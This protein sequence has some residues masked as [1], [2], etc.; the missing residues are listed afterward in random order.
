LEAVVKRRSISLLTLAVAAAMWLPSTARVDGQAAQARVI[1]LRGGT[2]Y[3]VTKGTIQNATV[4]IRDGKIA[5]VGTNVTVPS[6]AQVVD[7][8]GKHV[9]P[10]IIDA[11][12][13]IAN[14]SINEGGT[15]VSSMVGMQDVLDPT[16][17]NI[18]RDLGGG[19]TTAN[20]LHGSANPIGG[21]NAVIKL[22]WGAK[23]A[24]ELLFEGAMPGIKFALGEN[25][26]DI[27]TGQVTGPRRYPL[28]R[29]GV[30]Y[31]IRDA[32]TR[33]K[34]YQKAWK[35]YDAAKGGNPEAMPPRRDLQ[36]EALVEILEGKRLVHA[37]CYRA[38]E[39]LMLIRLAEEMGFK[40]ATFQ[41]VLEGYKVAKEI[42]AHGAGASTFADWWGY[43]IEA[44]DAIPHNAAIMVRK[45]VL[46]SINSDSAEHARRLNTEAGKTMRWGGLNED[47]ALALVTI[48]P[49]KQLRIDNR[50]GSLEVGKDAD[51]A[52]WTHHPLSSYTTADRVYIDG[53]LYYDRKGD[54]TRITELQKEKS[55]LAAAERGGRGTTPPSSQDGGDVS[56][57]AAARNN[58]TPNSSAVTGTTGAA[59]PRQAAQASGPILAIT[60]ARIFPVT[61]AA[62]D[63]GTIVI[64]GGRIEAVG[65]NVTVPQGATVID[66]KGGHVYP[67][68]IN[69]RTT[70]GIGE[71]GVRGYDDISEMLDWS[72][73][74]RTRVAYH[75]ESDTIPVARGTGVTTVGVAPTGGIMSG[76]FAVMNL[77]GWT[78][79]EATLRPNAGIAF[80]FPALGG[81]GGGR[82]GGGR[83]GRGGGEAAERTYDDIRRERDRRLD[84]VIRVFEQARAYAKAGANRARNWEL[85]AL[86]P[87][88]ERKLPLLVNVAR[89]QD[90]KDAVAFAERAS[91]NIVLSGAI[92]SNYAAQVL[93]D[94]N[95]P[96]IL[97]NVLAMPSREDSFHA[98]T[99]QLAG[100]L[101]RAGVKFAFSS[102]DNQNVRLVPFQ[103]GISVAWGLDRETAIKALT[104][105]AAQILGIANRVGSLEPG[106]DANLFIST[107]D[108]LE[109]RS[110]VTHIVIEGKDVGT[111]NK[112]EALYRKYIARQ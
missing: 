86:V 81:G 110:Q 102:G 46:V 97:G 12:S 29:M 85:E 41:H 30:E 9:T 36:L 108:P 38:D 55:A 26:K 72:Q 45:G 16:D 4:L 90:I 20:V 83:G 65:A 63:K 44:D 5:A 35:D 1:A 74:L 31:V 58:G 98:S 56:E 21:K 109:V 3:T 76:E 89:E 51:I 18:Y 24:E 57:S 79:E 7:V 42:A 71:D 111:D 54:E 64:R 66:A 107:G 99:Y 70:I 75:S 2:V 103:A 50:V 61:S 47:E 34:A 84:E 13:H 104:I 82:G 106:K 92:E 78:W 37:H 53:R 62:I 101:A 60:N 87:V 93:K 80:N 69:A 32:F 67:G 10:G 88:V 49:A 59:E 100:E 11:H 27:R 14:D 68:F 43:K 28:T 48:N 23:K 52:V 19:L 17:I 77:D 94:K 39:I 25:P 91:V 22:R 40:I 73:Q 105:D 112:H 96:V 33:A 6:D 8:T 95:I 15:T